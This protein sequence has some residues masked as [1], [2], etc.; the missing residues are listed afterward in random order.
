M[1]K[2]ILAIIMTLGLALGMVAC[3][4]EELPPE[5]QIAANAT[6]GSVEVEVVKVDVTKDNSGA[7][8]AVV[9][10][11]FVNNTN[12][13][14]QFKTSTS[15][16]VKQGETKLA[17]AVITVGDV[18]KE[19]VATKSVEEGG[20]LDVQMCYI[21]SDTTTPLSVTCNILSGENKATI[22]K[23]LPLS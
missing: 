6:T 13:A 10:F 8:A 22:E 12:K 20:T 2:K 17:A 11:K 5:E 3:G 16:T 1:G 18:Y 4:G 7:D 21:L 9:T 19:A 15:T 14:R 23:E